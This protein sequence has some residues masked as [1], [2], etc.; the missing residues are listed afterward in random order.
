VIAYGKINKKKAK[1]KVAKFYGVSYNK[2]P[3]FKKR[4]DN[5]SLINIKEP[6]PVDMVQKG[7]DECRRHSVL[8]PGYGMK[9]HL[10]QLGSEL[11][12]DIDVPNYE[13]IFGHKEP[14]PGAYKFRDGM[15]VLG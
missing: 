3:L 11:F 15:W 4:E 6:P 14:K 9:S 10:M 12:F 13:K 2:I 8:G 1:V 7:M 5:M